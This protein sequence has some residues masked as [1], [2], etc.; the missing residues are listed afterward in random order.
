MVATR[1]GSSGSAGKGRPV[2][3]SQNWQERVQ[4]PPKIMMVS[5]RRFQH[6]PMFGQVALSQ[7][8]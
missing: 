2:G 6:S 1:A 8:V 4:M 7:T 3:T 5:D